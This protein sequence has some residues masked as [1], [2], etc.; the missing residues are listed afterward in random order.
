MLAD[1]VQNS[2][3]SVYQLDYRV[4]GDGNGRSAIR[5]FPQLGR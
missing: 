5:E 4:S 2:H 3:Q 1:V